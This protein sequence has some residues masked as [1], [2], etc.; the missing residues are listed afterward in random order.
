MTWS[1]SRWGRHGW[2]SSRVSRGS[3]FKNCFLEKYFEVRN[4]FILLAT[5][6]KTHDVVK[7][8]IIYNQK[9]YGTVDNQQGLSSCFCLFFLGEWPI[10]AKMSRRTLYINQET[11]RWNTFLINVDN[12]LHVTIY[13]SLKKKS[14]DSRLCSTMFLFVSRPLLETCF[15][16][17]AA[18]KWRPQTNETWHIFMLNVQ[19]NFV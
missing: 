5:N 6:E 16:F 11:E 9:C 13:S 10:T 7:S 12:I 18:G 4:P 8:F 14:Y 1:L 15:V 2:K 3:W 17:F 19:N